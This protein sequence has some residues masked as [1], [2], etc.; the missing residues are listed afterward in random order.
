MGI[1]CRYNVDRASVGEETTVAM[2][3][4]SSRR[5]IALAGTSCSRSQ[6]TRPLGLCSCGCQGR[7]PPNPA[8]LVSVRFRDTAASCSAGCSLVSGVTSHSVGRTQLA[9]T[10]QDGRKKDHHCT[11][12][13][14]C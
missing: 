3:A 6:C 4:S 5:R 12:S 9:S 14:R 2:P 11:A 13:Q 8:Y 1:S 10:V 7:S